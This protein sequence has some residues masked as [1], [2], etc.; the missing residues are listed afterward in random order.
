MYVERAKAGAWVVLSDFS[1]DVLLIKR[2]CTAQPNRLHRFDEAIFC[3]QGASGSK[4]CRYVV[5]G[6][7]SEILGNFSEMRQHVPDGVVKR[8]IERGSK[9]GPRLL[10]EGRR[11]GIRC[12]PTPTAG[13]ETSDGCVMRETEIQDWKRKD[14]QSTPTTSQSIMA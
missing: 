8:W 3:G 1:H 2:A 14:A 11:E 4:K 9:E 5:V 6:L 10:S 7:C 13:L 12:R